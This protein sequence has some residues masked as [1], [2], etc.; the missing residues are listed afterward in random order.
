MGARLAAHAS[1]RYPRASVVTR[2]HQEMSST[3][4][5]DAQCTS[6]ALIA[7][8]VT[9]VQPLRLTS[10]RRAPAVSAAATGHASVTS[11]APRRRRVCSLGVAR[12]RGSTVSSVMRPTLERSRASSCGQPSSAAASA[13]RHSS[14]TCSLLAR[15]RRWSR[16]GRPPLPTRRAMASADA[17]CAPARESSTSAERPERLSRA[18]SSRPQKSRARDARVDPHDAAIARQAGPSTASQCVSWSV[19]SEQPMGDSAIATTSAEARR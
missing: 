8:S 2:R 14:V 5:L 1:V 18:A 16:A 19:R 11:C 3:A 15:Q 17:R 9:R 13:A 6:R 12:R 7:A 4:R 10:R